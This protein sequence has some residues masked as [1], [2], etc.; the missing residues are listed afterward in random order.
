MLFC[1]S[2]ITGSNKKRLRQALEPGITL[3]RLTGMACCEGMA[4]VS[5]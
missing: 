3:M 1:E 2:V 4:F 5:N